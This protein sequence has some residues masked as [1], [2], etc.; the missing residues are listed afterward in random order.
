MNTQ[1]NSHGTWKTVRVTC[2]DGRIQ[3]ALLDYA[4]SF[5][6]LSDPVPMPGGVKKF[7]ADE[8]YRE[9]TMEDV[10]TYMGLHG[11][12]IILIIQHEDCGAYGGKGA[13]EN[14]TTERQFHHQELERALPIFQERFPGKRIVAGFISL[15]GTVMV[16][17]D[18]T[19]S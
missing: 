5:G 12:D 6:G 8:G 3:R 4:E 7:L 1:N 2:G 9:K 18:L 16:F 17:E 11:Q 19:A 15:D 13:F 10:A 14:Q